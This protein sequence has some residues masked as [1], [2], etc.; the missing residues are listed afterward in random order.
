VAENQTWVGNRAVIASAAL[1]VPPRDNIA[2]AFFNGHWLMV[3]FVHN[4][5]AALAGCDLPTADIL[6]A[7]VTGRLQSPEVYWEF[8]NAAF[9]DG[10]FHHLAL[11]VRATVEPVIYRAVTF[12]ITATETAL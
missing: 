6:R 10:K 4:E 3:V 8:P 11:G 2:S 9:W 12:T 7:T 1:V 5:S